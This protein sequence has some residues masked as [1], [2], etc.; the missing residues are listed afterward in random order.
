M[1]YL[2]SPDGLHSIHKESDSPRHE[3]TDT[4]PQYF[5]Q[6]HSCE[7]GTGLGMTKKK[8]SKLVQSILST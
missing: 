7:Q 8:D 3:Q 1:H 6:S 4:R 5:I 2:Y